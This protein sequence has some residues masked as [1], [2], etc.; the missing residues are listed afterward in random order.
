M[1]TEIAAWLALAVFCGLA[2]FQI[3][4]ALG[5]PY[6]RAAWGGQYERLPANLRIASLFS[7]AVVA[8]L[9][10]FV[11]ERAAVVSV[12]NNPTLVKVVV[13]VAVGFFSLN[14]IANLAS[15]SRTEKYMAMVSLPLA[16]LCLIVALTAG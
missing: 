6:G 3:L 13:W 2:C 7:V 16:M 9:A 1:I 11:L 5:F 15:R 8:V 14:T 4:L 10:L 12:L